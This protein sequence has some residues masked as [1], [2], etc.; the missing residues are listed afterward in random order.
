MVSD[1]YRV[2]DKL[3][4]YYPVN[5][6]YITQIAAT[7]TPSCQQPK[8]AREGASSHRLI[9]GAAR[10]HAARVHNHSPLTSAAQHRPW[11]YDADG[12]AHMLA[13]SG[14]AAAHPRPPATVSHI[15]AWMRDG[16]RTAADHR[17]TTLILL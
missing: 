14:Y 9:E 15:A 17:R 11:R 1:G 6:P 7:T 3:Y 10:R 2:S 8:A 4:G 13:A 16:R 5:Y 12:A